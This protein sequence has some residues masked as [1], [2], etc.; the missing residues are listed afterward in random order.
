MY[1]YLIQKVNTVK[2]DFK[3]RLNKEQIDNSEPFPVA[4]LLVYLRIVKI[5]EQFCYDQKVPYHQVRLYY[6]HM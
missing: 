2:F 3:E 6:C 1:F 4:N 5:S